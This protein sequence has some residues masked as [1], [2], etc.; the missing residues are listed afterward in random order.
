MMD[1]A[2]PCLLRGNARVMAA[3]SWGLTLI[4]FT[5]CGS[6]SREG[7]VLE[8]S[9]AYLSAFQRTAED[10]APARTG[11]P[12]QWFKKNG[13]WHL[14]AEEVSLDLIVQV[15]AP[16]I[17]RQT[18]PP[19]WM[20]QPISIS[21]VGNTPLE[22]LRK[23][24]V[25]RGARLESS[26]SGHRITEVV[27]PDTKTGATL[28]RLITLRH[29]SVASLQQGLQGLISQGNLSARIAFG[30][31]ANQVFIV[32]D[33]QSVEHLAN[34]VVNLDRPA[35]LCRIQAWV[36]A[37]IN[38]DEL[39]FQPQPLFQQGGWDVNLSALPAQS[40]LLQFQNG[41]ISLALY[42]PS[43][44]PGKQQLQI[45]ALMNRIRQSTISAPSLLCLSGQSAM[46]QIGRTGWRLFTTPTSP[47]SS[48]IT[49]DKITTGV[50]LKMT[51]KVIDLNTV[52]LTIDIITSK[53]STA[54]NQLVANQRSREASSVVRLKKGGL[55]RLAGSSLGS[56]KLVS[57]GLTWLRSL[58]LLQWLFSA[59]DRTFEESAVD[60]YLTVDIAEAGSDLLTPSLF[61]CLGRS[62]DQILEDL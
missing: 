38:S 6:T 16:E 41:E 45:N 62:Q 60:F 47:T 40:E 33:S 56:Q 39:Y 46:L 32:G 8:T 42:S 25:V 35:A 11:D 58:P 18:L 55:I 22:C 51:P 4:C 36:S 20:G 43:E 14:V 24:A 13:L 54:T 19:G 5:S 30:P 61:Q 23:L 59:E 15:I 9:L 57:Q 17:P 34:L 21:L 2:R 12:L 44:D 29:I 1:R 49:V 52:D 28:D 10:L 26:P 37:R 53:F 3:I 48:S 7:E 27:P 50:T 31:E